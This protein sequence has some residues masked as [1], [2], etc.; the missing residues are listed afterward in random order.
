MKVLVKE[1]ETLKKRG[2]AK[3]IEIVGEGRGE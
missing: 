3:K 1:M 2:Q